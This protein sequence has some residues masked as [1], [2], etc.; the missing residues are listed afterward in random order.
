MKN[1]I[2]LFSILVTVLGL[3]I[4]SV[5]AA[6]ILQNSSEETAA[7]YLRGYIDMVDADVTLTDQYAHTLAGKIKNDVRV[8]FI[9]FDGQIIGES[10]SDD[11]MDGHEDREEVKEAIQDGYG[12]AE[13]KSTLTY[14]K[15]VYYAR[16]VDNGIIRMSIPVQSAGDVYLKILPAAVTLMIF[17]I[18]LCFLISN[19]LTKQLL[20]P[21]KEFSESF[22]LEDDDGGNLVIKSPYREF[23]PIARR[24]EEM[25]ERI[26]AQ[27][28]EIQAISAKE[29]LILDNITIGLIILDK[30]KRITLINKTAAKMLNFQPNHDR[31]IHYLLDDSDMLNKIDRNISFD[32]ERVEEGI[33]TRYRVNY[34]EQYESTVIIM[35]DITAQK[36]AERV[37]ADFFNN[38][39][40]EMNTPLTG[41][42]GFAEIMLLKD[43][44]PSEVKKYAKIIH[45]ESVRL[46]ELIKQILL[47]SA[48]EAKPVMEAVDIVEVARQV[49]EVMKPAADKSE[50]T[51][52]VATESDKDYITKTS[53]NGVRDILT[54]LVAN[55]VKYNRK[56]GYV[57]IN[58]GSAKSGRIRLEVE[59][60]GIGI[61]KEH[62]DRVFERFY[63]V[64]LSHNSKSTGGVGLGL[65]IVKKTAAVIGA[66]I[67]VESTSGVGT[68]FCILL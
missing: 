13:R 48:I 55:S 33:Y 61:P 66:K 52:A 16:K 54:N 36:S 9:S 5:A 47:Y 26:K 64:N 38:V 42:N 65:A 7:D 59:D 58:I 56:G 11:P 14:K 44:K 45:G 67:T 22:T 60:N 62:L 3:L 43:L 10:Q 23:E 8:T 12:H 63:T 15:T 37:K 41:I 49:A 29:K 46:I 27:I 28:K 53:R 17:D 24:G 30:D 34:I 19:L 39:T 6:I 4:F 68:K 25:L 21:V 20:K 18:A 31:T 35:S 2:L 32:T 50:I 51:V 1:R 57:S 40:H